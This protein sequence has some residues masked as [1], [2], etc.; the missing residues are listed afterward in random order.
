VNGGFIESSQYY[1]NERERYW[2][3][4]QLMDALDLPAPAK[5]LEI[6]GGQIAV[7]RKLL[8]EDDTVA[9]DISDK[10]HRPV[11]SLGIPFHILD[12]NNPVSHIANINERFD[13]IVMLEVIE[14][15][16]RPAYAVLEPL[17]SLLKP[18]GLFFLTTPN[19]FRLRNL[20]RMAAGIEFV[21]RFMVPAPGQIMGHQLEYSADHLRWQVERAGLEVVMLI[22]DNLGGTGHSTN[23]KIAKAALKFLSVRPLWRDNLVVAA[24]L[25]I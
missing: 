25:T 21:D 23:T 18:S 4:L 15:I 14:H 20:L 5:I 2:R 16:S 12:L 19:L 8:I 3:T 1:R 10:F 11:T 24:R 9:A 7:L 6:G 17:K 13:V 22:H